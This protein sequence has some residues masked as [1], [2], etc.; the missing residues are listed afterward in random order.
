MSPN[1]LFRASIAAVAA[2]S[3]ASA[4]PVAFSASAGNLAASATFATSG[5]NL[6]VTL[7]NTSTSD[8]LI[9]ADVLTAVFFDVS[10][11]P[12]SLTPVSALLEAGSVVHFG[13]S[14]GGDVGGEWAYKSGLAGPYGAYGIGSAGFGIFGPPDMF[15]GPNLQGPVGPNGLEYGITSAGDNPATGNAPVTGSNALIQNSV[16]FTLSGLPAGFS[17]SQIN[18]VVWQY[19]T[20]TGSEPHIPAPGSIALL[21]LAGVLAGGRRR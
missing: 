5:S 16:V 15:P 18:N 4:S 8:V 21:A 9:P 12:L 13:P 1:V 20:D 6:V 14:N 17:L 7:T 10:G 2:S 19:G 11:G 3:V